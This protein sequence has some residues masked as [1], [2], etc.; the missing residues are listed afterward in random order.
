MAASLAYF[1]PHVWLSFS[2]SLARI[3][4]GTCSSWRAVNHC[5]NSTTARSKSRQAS[6]LYPRRF[7]F[8]NVLGR[9]GHWHARAVCSI[10]SPRWTKHLQLPRRRAVGVE[11]E[12]QHADAILGIDVADEPDVVAEELVRGRHQPGA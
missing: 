4:T 7:R 12:H 10:S 8:Q 2:L 5:Q 3:R 11:R 6:S 9:V 1:G